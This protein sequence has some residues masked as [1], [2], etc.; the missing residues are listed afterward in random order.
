V[1]VCGTNG[2]VNAAADG[3]Q[4]AGVAASI[5]RTERYGGA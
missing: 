5:I 3:A 4:A 1:F 2:F